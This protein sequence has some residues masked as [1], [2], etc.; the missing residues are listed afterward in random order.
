MI[1]HGFGW[2]RRRVLEAGSFALLA[3]FARPCMAIAAVAPQF[4]RIHKN[5]TVVTL[6]GFGDARDQSW[7]SPALRQAFAESSELWL[8]TAPAPL[9][10]SPNAA[11]IARWSNLQGRSL[12]DV[13]GSDLS[14]RVRQRLTEFEVPESS[15]AGQMPWRAYYAINGAY[16]QRHPQP[17]KAQPVDGAL[18]DLAIASGKPVSSEFLGFAELAE[19]MGSMS[20]AAQA[21]Y[22]DWLLQALDERDAGRSG[23][24]FAWISG[25]RPMASLARMAALPDLFAAM[26]IGRNRW[27]A[28]KIAELLSARRSAFIAV[29][30]LHVMGVAGIP[31]QLEDLGLSPKQAA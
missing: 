17:W 14:A 2:S 10:K 21:Q 1:T 5:G 25:E 13:L 18:A 15:V 22:V 8:E 26:Q 23:N 24:P 9:Q 6:F 16:W 27:W 3:G 28:K 12:F 31:R 7:F 29:G 4:W 30:Q 20:D 11:Q 19:F